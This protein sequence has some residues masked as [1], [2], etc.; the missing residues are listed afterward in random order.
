VASVVNRFK[1][2]LI[3]QLTSESKAARDISLI[4]SG[5]QNDLMVTIN[6]LLEAV[7]VGGIHVVIAGS[8]EEPSKAGEFP[9]SPYAAAKAASTNYARMVSA[10]AGQQVSILRL[11]MVYGPRQA[12]AKVFPFVINKLRAGELAELGPA[13]RLLD[14]VYVDDVVDAFLKVGS[15]PWLNADPIDIGS[16]RLMRLREC[17][18][19]IGEMM[20]RPD[21]L[22]F[23]VLGERLFEREDTADLTLAGTRL[24]WEPFTDFRHGMQMTIDSMGR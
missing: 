22:K 13:Q 14:W 4:P 1:P 12:A 8:F 19:I 5:I 23:G 6:V 20:G 18:E 17:V 10:L 16:G 7:R 11:M 2:D 15:S 21:L 3:Y 24:A 9:C